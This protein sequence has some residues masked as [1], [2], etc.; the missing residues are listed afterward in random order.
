MRKKAPTFREERMSE[1][2]YAE[3]YQNDQAIYSNFQKHPGRKK[4]FLIPLCQVI[5]LNAT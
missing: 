1:Y 3:K 4:D 5:T 2:T